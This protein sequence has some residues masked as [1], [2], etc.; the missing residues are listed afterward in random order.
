MF[1]LA[2][3]RLTSRSLLSLLLLATMSLTVGITACIPAFAGAVSLRI[4]QQ[5]IDRRSEVKGLPLFSVRVLAEPTAA[6]PMTLAEVER[7]REWLGNVMQR[8]LGLPIESVNVEVESPMYRLTP[9]LGDE[10]YTT[11]Y[12]AGLRVVYAQGLGDH[13]RIVAGEPYG[14]LSADP[15]HLNV[16]VK[17]SFLE[18]LAIEVGEIYDLGGLYAVQGQGIPVRIAGT[19]EVVDDDDPYWLRLLQGQYAQDLLTSAEM[20][21]RHVSERL[22]E[23]ASLLSWHFVFDQQRVNLGRAERYISGLEEIGRQVQ[24]NLPSGRVG[25][26]PMEE[27]LRGRRRKTSL[28]IVLYGF[29]LPIMVFLVYFVA[30]LS[31]MQA[32]Y[33]EAET[34][35][36]VSRGSTARQVLVVASIESLLLGA[37]SI[38]A[39]AAIGLLLAQLLGFA[40]G[41]L[42]LAYREPLQVNLSSV[43]WWL[44]IGVAAV[45]LLV[46]LVAAWRN[47]RTTIISHGQ[48]RARGRSARARTIRAV[49][50]YLYVA[51]LALVTAYA[52]RQLEQRG[53]LALA[54]LNAFDPRN[55]PLLLLAPTLFLFCGPLLAVEAFSLLSVPLGFVGR[56]LSGVAGY[57]AMTNLARDGR[58][59]R[60]PTYV[61][62]LSLSIGVFY[63]SIA[64]SADI[65]LLDSKRYAYGADLTF[66]V[67]AM[68]EEDR[69]PQ[70]AASAGIEIPLV[71]SDDYRALDG[72]RDAARVAEFEATIHGQRDIP[73]VRLLALDRLDFPRVAYF[74]SDYAVHSLGELMNRMALTSNGFLMPSSL[75][76][77][78]R[79]VE[80][81]TLRLNVNVYQD[82][83]IPFEFVLVGTFDFFPTMFPDRAPVLVVGLDHLEVH[84]IGVL[85]HGVWL[86]LE[87]Q[88][89]GKAVMAAVRR[90][91]VQPGRVRDLRET[92]RIESERL[93]RTGVFGLL[94]ICFLA[95][96]A[97]SVADL[98]VYNTLMLR[99]RSVS[100]AVLR[101]LG[102]TRRQVLRMLM[103]E[104]VVALAYGLVL[105]IVGGVFCARLYVPF[106]ALGDASGLPIPPFIPFIDWQGTIWI[107][108]TMGLALLVAQAA[109]LLRTVRARLFE[110]LRMGNPP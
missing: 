89:E 103:I 108:A 34:A 106:F 94:S 67:G 19:Y 80:G 72:V 86:Q 36:L 30:S 9:R 71:P 49:T 35:M 88:A 51:L 65:W 102:L 73:A 105:G 87:P 8:T 109:V 85:P 16:W 92:L 5:E 21:D 90:L 101:A 54:S 38:P 66:Q 23:G 39:G 33:Q 41:F 43:D 62:I 32:R 68:G 78:M 60:I 107:A 24:R 31:A 93:E 17:Q 15:E 3:K 100:H 97:L 84:T 37:A 70:P 7:T 45:N 48:A 29:S 55:D 1:L 57:L 47:R 44:V 6:R 79:L 53:T 28:S 56:Y 75:A 104:S 50:R 63:A 14:T 69:G 4:M 99:Q 76:S 58:H 2:L 18:E 98:F 20:F 10:T 82:T 11:Q 12:L 52:Y 46:R 22:E 95:G 42:S 81:D 40:T 96:A 13:T 27:L 64:K 110:A 61:L 83:L 91:Q 74:R 59:L 26:A 77:R 25:I